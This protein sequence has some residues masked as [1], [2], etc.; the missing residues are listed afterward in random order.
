MVALLEEHIISILLDCC[1]TLGTYNEQSK[2]AVSVVS[3]SQIAVSTICSYSNL[4]E[5]ES[6]GHCSH[7]VTDGPQGPSFPR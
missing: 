2:D 3:S 7:V 1:L 4:V 6:K 5:S